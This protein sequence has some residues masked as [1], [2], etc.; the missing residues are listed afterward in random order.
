VIRRRSSSL[1]SIICGDP[2]LFSFENQMLNFV[3][4][5]ASLSTLANAVENAL[6]GIPVSGIMYVIA[7]LY[8]I[9][10][11]LVRSK[12]V[13]IQPVTVLTTIIFVIMASFAW[14]YNEGLTGS[15]P[16]FFIMPVIICIAI[17][18]GWQR[19]L[20]VFLLLADL[21]FLSY[22]QITRP[23]TVQ[24][25]PTEQ[26]KYLDILYSFGL[27]TIYALGYITISLA[28]LDQRRKQA[29]ELL[30]NILPGSIAEKLK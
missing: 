2:Y 5:F 22:L 14:F 8:F 19:P 17:L 11:L 10:Y 23:E 24:P 9:G 12:R 25:Y 15:T 30:L 18:R 29:D 27:I 16:Y 3:M 1:L 13:P 7:P 26:A 6:L 20:F 21:L 4:L 28:N